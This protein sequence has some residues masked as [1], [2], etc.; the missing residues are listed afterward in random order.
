MIFKNYFN[1]LVSTHKMSLNEIIAQAI[2]CP[3]M[4]CKNVADIIAG[5]CQYNIVEEA[6]NKYVKIE[7]S[8]GEHPDDTMYLFDGKYFYVL[9]FIQIVEFEK[10][11]PGTWSYIRNASGGFT[12]DKFNPHKHATQNP[13]NFIFTKSR[14]DSIY[15]WKIVKRY[16]T[17]EAFREAIYI[18]DLR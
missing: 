4:D 6:E 18:V 11:Q 17:V 14:C 10:G 9:D 8:G 7:V 16:N 3:M 2:D 1:S 15:L 13:G 5:Y 12:I